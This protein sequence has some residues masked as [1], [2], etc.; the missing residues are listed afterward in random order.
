MTRALAKKFASRAR[1]IAALFA[2]AL[3]APVA[4][5]QEKTQ[6]APQ[7]KPQTGAL[8]EHKDQIL[9]VRIGM[10][11]PEALKAVFEHTATSPA[12][13]KPDALKEEGKDKKD[14]RIAYKNLNEGELQIVFAGGKQGLVREIT[15]VYA[16]QPTMSDLK[17]P[18]TGSINVRTTRNDF[19]DNVINEGQ[20]YDTRYSVGFTDDQ[21]TERYWWRDERT[22]GGYEVRIGFISKKIKAKNSGQVDDRILARKV[23]MVKPG[24]EKKFTD[25]V[26]PQ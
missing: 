16:K 20:V 18:P 2:V 23:I 3:Y 8:G 13:Q 1:L 19:L 12:P 17:L 5:A 24:D 25:I 9:G 11:V 21:K 6:D 26:A 22:P 10:S 14:I 4:F 15:L 7:A